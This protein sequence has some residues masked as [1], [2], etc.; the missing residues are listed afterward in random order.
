MPRP[1][2]QDV[3]Q[4]RQASLRI[5]QAS[6]AVFVTMLDETGA[7]STRAMFNLR[8]QAQ[9]PGLAELFSEHNDDLLVH[10]ATNTSSE[11][12]RHLRRDPRVAL[13]YCVPGDGDGVMLA[14]RVGM[15]ADDGLKRVLWQ[16][17]WE[18]YFP[19]GVD[20]PDYTVLTLRP[21]H[22]RGW[23]GRAAFDFHLVSAS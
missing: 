20:D 16:P 7:P 11:K 5:M 6:E 4:A 14:G 3:G 2:M 1:Q 19:Q 21:E 17:G 10:L 13:Y 23:V 18:I 22:I 9:F 8:R 12:C 15:A